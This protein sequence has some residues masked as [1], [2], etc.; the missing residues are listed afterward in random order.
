MHST[1]MN[2]QL[3]MRTQWKE[4]S[5]QITDYAFFVSFSSQSPVRTNYF[6][7][8]TDYMVTLC[9]KV[10]HIQLPH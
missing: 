5:T 8:L 2:S 4:N 1:V 7:K 9:V 3:P 6:T 10:P